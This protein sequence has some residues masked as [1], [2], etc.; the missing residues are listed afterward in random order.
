MKVGTDGVILGAFATH[1]NA[2]QVLDIGSG[3]GLI[4]LMLAQRHPHAEI[5]GIE[6]DQN[7]YR[8][9]RQNM[10]NSPWAE[11]LTAIDSD[12]SNYFPSTS[13]D[14]LVSNPPFFEANE[15]IAS[16][17]RSLARQNSSLTPVRIFEFSQKYLSEQGR[18]FLIYPYD[19][20]D[21]TIEAGK[22]H[23]LH[24]HSV[25][26]IRPN[27]LKACKR[28][29]MEFRHEKAYAVKSSILPVEVVRRHDYSW[30]Y[31]KITRDYYLF[32]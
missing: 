25:V 21:H 13:F 20:F 17:S 30:Q 26:Y 15:Q 32:F 12:I 23:Y 14:L 18:L 19:K 24:L 1:E 5:T 6:S 16:E 22:N 7:A 10:T 8:Q 29:V 27:I 2:R 3:T 4:S 28:V 31:K 9:S 11:R